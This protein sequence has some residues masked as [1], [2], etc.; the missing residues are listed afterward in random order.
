[1]FL[2]PPILR[3]FQFNETLQS[4]SEKCN[5]CKV[6]W[7]AWLRVLVWVVELP[8]SEAHALRTH[9]PRP[10]SYLCGHLH[11]AAT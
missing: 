9:A 2:G 7:Y 11:G 3:S 6:Q 1:V 10:S 8:L 5:D 4:T